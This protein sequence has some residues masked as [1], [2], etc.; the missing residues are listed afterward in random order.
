MSNL[1]DEHLIHINAQSNI[2][3]DIIVALI[4]SIDIESCLNSPKFWK[5][6][7]KLDGGQ[8]YSIILELINKKLAC[9]NC[10]KRSKKAECGHNICSDCINFQCI[11]CKRS[12]SQKDKKNLNMMLCFGCFKE[13]Q[14]SL[15]KDTDCLHLC[16]LCY[17]I[18]ISKRRKWCKICKNEYQNPDEYI[19]RN[20]KC[21]RKKCEYNG[22]FETFYTLDCNHTFCM[23]CLE[24]VN[25]KRR[26]LRCPKNVLNNDLYNIQNRWSVA[27]EICN[28]VKNMN[29]IVKQSCCERDIC[30]ECHGGVEN[31]KF[32]NQFI[33]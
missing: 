12:P 6:F 15:F 8:I 31:C 13:K 30:L 19:Q 27:C 28:N 26:C 9:V 5:L 4:G 2:I 21:D 29:L 18:E 7:A 17:F 22:I 11:V 3:E 16:K 14:Y 10:K 24:K 20:V 23:N 1:E 32:C 25:K 33:G